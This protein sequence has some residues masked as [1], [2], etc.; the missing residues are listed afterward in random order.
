MCVSSLRDLGYRSDVQRDLQ[1]FLNIRDSHYSI[2][3]SDSGEIEI[4]T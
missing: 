1:G 2:R 4:L 3:V